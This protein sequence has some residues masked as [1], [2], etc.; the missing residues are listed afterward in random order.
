METPG[1]NFYRRL[2]TNLMGNNLEV[3]ITRGKRAI[4][5][6]KQRGMD[7]SVWEKELARLEALAQ[8]QEVAK[9]TS[10]FL[11][12]RGWCLWKCEALDG[13][14]ILIADNF[15]EDLPDGYPIYAIS[16]LEILFGGDNPVSRNTLKLL[17]EAKKLAEAKVTSKVTSNEGGEVDH[18]RVKGAK[19]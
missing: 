8:A 4:T 5:L 16:E 7:I 13:D 17:H 3:R 14:T 12:T 15:A 1:V 10:E 11:A 9:R 2:K 6:A 18:R 19:D